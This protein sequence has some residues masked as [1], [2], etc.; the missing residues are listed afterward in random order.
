[1]PGPTKTVSARLPESL[2]KEAS[3]LRP[4]STTSE[5]IVEALAAWVQQARRQHEDEVIRAALGSRSSG[6][7]D[8]ERELA[9]AA[10]RSARR[11]VERT[12]G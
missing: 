5:M 12:D 2:L 6:E 8:E 10:G 9:R 1:M 4:G 11:V 7:R 3:F